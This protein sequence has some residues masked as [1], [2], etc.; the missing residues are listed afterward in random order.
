MKII[1]GLLLTL[2]CVSTHQDL[3]SL[4]NEINTKQNL[5]TAGKNFHDTPFSELG[6]LAGTKQLPENIL[7]TIPVVIHDN[8]TDDIPESFDARTQWPKCK[9][10]QEI[11]D[12]SACRSDWV[13]L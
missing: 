3:D 11:R 4:I 9:S 7:R 2:T 13:S 1:L 8:N 6:F 5:W 12:Q 10:I